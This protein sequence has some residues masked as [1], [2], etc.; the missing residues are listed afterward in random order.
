MA[1]HPSSRMNRSVG[2]PSTDDVL[3]IENIIL[4]IALDEFLERGYGGAS[5]TRIVEKACIS[6]TTLYSRYGSKKELFRA[7]IFHQ[8]NRIDPGSLLRLDS[9]DCSLEQG[10][11]SYA[12][13]MLE[14]NLQGEMHA[15]NKLINSEA[16]R[17]PELGAAAAERTRLG[18]ARIADFIER[19]AQ[20]E[21][22]RCRN[23]DLVAQAFIMMLRGWYMNI[24]LTNE[25]ITTAKRKKWVEGVVHI[26]LADKKNW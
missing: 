26:L 17:F 9:K 12:N 4:Q 19:C 24:L 1:R 5:L 14:L 13:R 2:R 20:A 3:E 10:L 16:A 6:K 11:Q 25:T 22:Y 18:I 15:L 7:I 21:G 8:I 23:A